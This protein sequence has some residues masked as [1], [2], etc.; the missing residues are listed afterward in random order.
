[1][2]NYLFNILMNSL[3]I[4]EKVQKL[5][6]ILIEP[7]KFKMNLLLKPINIYIIFKVK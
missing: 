3:R 2:K 5:K 4:I 6:C 1:M 7:N